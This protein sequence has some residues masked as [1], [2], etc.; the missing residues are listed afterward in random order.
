MERSNHGGAAEMK[1]CGLT[2]A[3]L[4]C[5]AWGEEVAEDGFSLL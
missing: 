2:A 4:P 1:S 5:T 3:S